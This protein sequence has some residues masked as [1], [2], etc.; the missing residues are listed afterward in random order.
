MYVYIY[1]YVYIDK[2]IYI[3]GFIPSCYVVVLVFFAP[4]MRSTAKFAT[5]VLIK[6]VTHV[7]LSR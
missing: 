5:T 7:G 2:Y 3:Y 6:C 4:L 1:M